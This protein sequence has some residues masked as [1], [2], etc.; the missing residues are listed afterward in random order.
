M[1]GKSRSKESKLKIG[2]IL[3]KYQFLRTVLQKKLIIK[4]S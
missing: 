1:P 2:K 4:L 3:R